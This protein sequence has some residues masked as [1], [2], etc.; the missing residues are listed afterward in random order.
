MPQSPQSLFFL[1]FTSEF[2]FL[3]GYKDQVMHTESLELNPVDLFSLRSLVAQK[4]DLL[5]PKSPEGLLTAKQQMTQEMKLQQHTSFKADM[6]SLFGKLLYQETVA[7]QLV[8]PPYL[9]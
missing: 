6:M 5:E 7:L 8:P 4:V 3:F 9:C 2:E 1:Q